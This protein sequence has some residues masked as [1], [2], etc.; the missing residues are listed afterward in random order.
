MSQLDGLN[1]TLGEYGQAISGGQARRIALAR[2]LL[3]PKAILLLDEPFAGL[4]KVSRDKLWQNLIHHQQNGLLIIV[5]HHVW[6]AV[7][8]MDIIRLP[9]P[10]ILG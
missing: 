7:D 9:E 1:T 5:T 8:E 4:D 2:L 3:T 10:E 6:Q